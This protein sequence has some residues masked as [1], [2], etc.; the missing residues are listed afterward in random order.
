MSS[1]H[2]RHDLTPQMARETLLLL[3][4]SPLPDSGELV[5]RARVHD[6][7]IGRRSSPDKVI[8]SL[9]DLGLI[10]RPKTHG[11][12]LALTPLGNRVADVAVRDSLLMA[13]LIHLRYAS[14]WT[15]EAGGEHFSWAYRTVADLLWDG[16]PTSID[17]D[18]LV[19]TILASADHQF[20]V[21]SI[22][23]SSSS[24]LGILHWLRALSP[25]CIHNGRFWRR[26]ACSPEALTLAIEGLQVALGRPLG[27][28]IR[29]DSDAKE[30]VCRILLLDHA[31][32]D[33]MLADA[34][35]TVGLIRRNGDGG[36]IVLLRASALP[37]L[38]Y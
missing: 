11:H 28:P 38:V 20:A 9:R 10:E 16:A 18:R 25:P 4:A 30:R 13:E 26:S 23:F 7:D 29:L 17:T 34:E 8:A 6:F 35:E 14:L 31:A 24:V 5:A 12:Q 22:S 19:A 37:G 33:E 21:R 27:A 36:E 15:P 1:F 2:V 3:A 32:L